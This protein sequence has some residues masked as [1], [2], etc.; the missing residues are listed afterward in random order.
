MSY[1]LINCLTLLF[2]ATFPHIYNTV[3]LMLNKHP[4]QCF[5]SVSRQNEKLFAQ[6]TVTVTACQRSVLFT[7]LAM[8]RKR[9]QYNLK[10]WS[11]LGGMGCFSKGTWSASKVVTSHLGHFCSEQTLHNF[12]RNNKDKLLE[13]QTA[14]I[15][16]ALVT[17]FIADNNHLVIAWKFQRE[18][19]SAIT[20]KAS[21]R[22]VI[23]AIPLTVRQRDILTAFPRAI[24]NYIDPNYPSPPDFPRFHE[25]VN[26]VSAIN[27]P[28][29]LLRSRVPDNSGD[30]LRS[31]VKAVFLTDMLAVLEQN[32]SAMHHLDEEWPEAPAAFLTAEHKSK[33][34]RLY[35]LF[36]KNRT[37]LFRNTAVFQRRVTQLWKNGYGKLSRMILLPMAGLMLLRM[38]GTH[39]LFMRSET[40]PPLRTLEASS[41]RCLGIVSQVFSLNDRHGLFGRHSLD[42]LRNQDDVPQS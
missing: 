27:D 38:V 9:N 32:M 13:A 17:I 1:K 30:C 12:M 16:G 41:I 36:R 7:F 14:T 10:H 39:G 26:W 4:N 37:K 2:R 42:S 29:L 35:S 11:I 28:Q 15:R 20:A 22:L 5:A 24:I 3:D 18:G 23:L 8:C 33:M 25:V 21:S 6:D 40:A 31:Y 34:K 19:H